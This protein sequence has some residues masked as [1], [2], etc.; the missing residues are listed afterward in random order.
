[1]K[2]GGPSCK[3]DIALDSEEAMLIIC[4]IATVLGQAAGVNSKT[5]LVS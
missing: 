4:S 3:D 2:M 5:C 1:M